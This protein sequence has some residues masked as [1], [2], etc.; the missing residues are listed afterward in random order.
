MQQIEH[1]HLKFLHIKIKW[2]MNIEIQ[3]W[4][5]TKKQNNII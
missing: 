4:D 2:N 3:P 1:H 5:G